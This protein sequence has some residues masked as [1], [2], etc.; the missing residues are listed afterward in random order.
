[1]KLSSGTSLTIPNVVRVAYHSTLVAHYLAYCEETN[2]DPLSKSSLYKILSECPASRRTNLKGLDNIAA[3]GNAA[4]ESLITIIS[5]LEDQTIDNCL[6]TEFKECKE[7]L[8]SSRLYL[9]TE[10]KLHVEKE[11]RCP[12]H[13]INYALSDNTNQNL[14]T[15]CVSH[16]HD[17]KCKRCSDLVEAITALR[18]LVSK[19]NGMYR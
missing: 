16:H 19:L 14:T 11:N 1:M 7:K 5:E 3:D 10:Y 13:C 4:F 18:S 6:Q 15:Q 12:D 17:M 2:F 8:L 9:K